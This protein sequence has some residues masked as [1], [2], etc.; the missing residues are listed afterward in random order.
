MAAARVDAAVSAG[1]KA[2]IARP[3]SGSISTVVTPGSAST[4]FRTCDSQPPQV[5]PPTSKVVV[6]RLTAHPAVHLLLTHVV[7]CHYRGE[8]PT[9]RRKKAETATRPKRHTWMA[10]G[11]EFG[12]Q[13]SGRAG[14][15]CVVG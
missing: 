10:P 4:A 11:L 1:S 3:D 12:G 9:A 5:I 14:Q 13:T 6:R 7:A 2:T 8:R 15:R